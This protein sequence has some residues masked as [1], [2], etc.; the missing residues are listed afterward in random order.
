MLFKSATLAFEPYA[1]RAL[2]HCLKLAH[3]SEMRGA[4]LRQYLSDEH[5]QHNEITAEW[6]RQAGMQTWV[7]AVG[8]QWGRFASEHAQAP[9]L[10]L[11]SHLDTV[12]NAGAFDGI[13]G[14]MLAIQLVRYFR[15]QQI[16]LP[17]HIDVVGFCDEEGTRF[18]VT[19]I[20][21]RALAGTF[22][23]AWL[24]VEDSNGVSMQDAM[25]HFGLAPENYAQAALTSSDLLGFWEVHIE[26]G[27]VLEA[28]ELS[29]GVVTAIAGAK[30]ASLSIRG[31]AGHAGTTPMPLRKDALCAAA[32]ISLAVERRAKE[33]QD[34]RVATVGEFMVRPG[35]VNVIAGDAL[36]SLDVRAQ[37]D[38]KRDELISVI[39]DDVDQIAAKRHVSVDW[40]WHHQATAVPCAEEFQQLF[41][42]A[43]QKQG[44]AMQYLPS[45]A[46]HDAMAI[47]EIC[48]IAMLFI[49]SPRGLSHHPDEA[50][51][52]TDVFD[53]MAVMVS[54]VELLAAQQQSDASRL[55][56]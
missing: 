23:P 42:Q 6:M 18:G 3:V 46:G 11:G 45:G 16:S 5:R 50:V 13:L 52:P 27:P 12:P 14:V 43:C 19:L 39:A 1:Q 33:C 32:E 25:Q 10:V 40:H 47:A 53:A 54:A 30:R 17:F 51:I 29:L 36:I 21:S 35:A 15:D 38:E 22:D 37:N 56:A 24:A 49:R 2:E 44:I 28:N 8:N 4:T 7:D 34:D 31:L 55:S 41:S 20:G 26:Q 48:P 9:R